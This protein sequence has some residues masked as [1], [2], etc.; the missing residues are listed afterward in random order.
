MRGMGFDIAAILSPTGPIAMRLGERY[1]HRPEQ[2]RMALAVDEAFTQRKTTVIEAGTG[3]G[4][5]FSYLLPAIKHILEAKARASEDGD[6]PRRR[7][8]ISTHTI[9]LQEQ[10]LNKDIPFLRNAL[11]GHLPGDGEFTAVLVKGRGNYVSLRRLARTMDR[12]VELFA[13]HDEMRTLETIQE[14]SRT[15]TDG[16]LTT[17]PQLQKP[18]IWSSVQ[19]DSEDCQGRRC[20]TYMKCFY[21]SARRRME[22]ADLLVVNHALFFADLQ[23]REEG[24]G[25]LPPYDYVVLDEAHTV[26]DVASDHFGVSASRFQVM[27]LITGLYTQRGKGILPALSHKRGS[28]TELLDRC[29]RAVSDVAYATDVL[30]DDLARWQEQTGRTNGRIREPDIV[31]NDLSPALRDL[32]IQLKMLR[33]KL[34]DA[35]DRM[36]INGYALRAESLAATLTALVSQ[37]LPDHVYWLE[38]IQKG[39]TPR[40]KLSAS[41]VEVGS[42]L[43]SRLFEA[44]NGRDEP[45][46]VVLTSATLATSARDDDKKTGKTHDPFAHV[47]SRLGCDQANTLLLGSPF[48]YDRQC[49]LILESS[50]PEPNDPK[51]L[52][53]LGPCLVKHIDR[54]EGG[55]FILFTGY[56]LLKRAGDFLRPHLAQRSMPMLVQ[57]EGV[58]RSHMLEAFR[59]DRRSVLLGVESFWQGVDVQGEALRN[60]IITRLP[61]AVPDRPL[62]EARIERITAR[63]GNAFMEYSLPEA[64]LKFKQ[65]FGRLIR[66]R[67]DTGT[68]V[69]TDRRITTKRYGKIFLHALPTMPVEIHDQPRSGGPQHDSR[70]RYTTES[71]EAIP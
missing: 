32:S 37:K 39:R 28:P 50:L 49:R 31:P 14:W 57:G 55:A 9:A 5:S 64:V 52:D 43:R 8:V 42:L 1:D 15:T 16:S 69:V 29:I 71:P 38:V 63:G 7:V 53:A 45:L 40:V 65:G 22:N 46:G 41:P 10:L 11:A 20:P 68:V 62:T 18:T 17:L 26:E 58:Q 60:V 36:E 2:G 27:L 33:D 23:L 56:D 44:T 59:G 30:F 19:S 54:T 25:L 6:L 66:S 67:T 24:F 21:Q 61:F 12:R 34:D 4:K 51:Y 35:D 47:R 70:T 13:D 3:V 48:D